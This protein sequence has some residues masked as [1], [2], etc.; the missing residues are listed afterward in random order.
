MKK[1]FTT[2]GNSALSFISQESIDRVDKAEQAP[3]EANTTSRRQAKKHEETKTRRVQ[4]LIQP[5]VYE[6]V[7]DKADK[8]GISTNEAIIQAIRA[9]TK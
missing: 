9:Y 2:S 7:R 4:I 6:A 1:D 8:E 3:P 5:S